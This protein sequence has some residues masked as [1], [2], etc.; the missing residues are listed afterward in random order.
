MSDSKK[1]AESIYQSINS[2]FS[3]FDTV[4]EN[5]N[6]LVEYIE[7][8]YQAKNEL[9]SDIDT[10]Y[11][12]KE[13][14]KEKYQNALIELYKKEQELQAYSCDGY[15]SLEPL[16]VGLFGEWGSGKTRLLKEI[17]NQVIQK[18]ERT[19]KIWEEKQQ[20]ELNPSPLQIPIFFNAWRF[21]KDEHIIIPLF[22]TMLSELEKYDYI[23]SIKVIKQKLQILL[24]SIVKNLQM[25]KDFDIS[26]IFSKDFKL[27]A[28]G[29]FFNIGSIFKS[30][31]EQEQEQ[32]KEHSYLLEQ[33]LQSG[34]LES[35]YVQI[36]KWIEKITILDNVRFI[37]LID[38]LDRCLPEN[39]LKMLESIKLFLDVPGCAFVL[40]VD[41][42]VVERG[43]EHHYR[44]YLQ[45][46]KYITIR[47][48]EVIQESV[49]PNKTN[50]PITGAEYLEKMVQLPF[51]IPQQDIDDVKKIII[52]RYSKRF[53]FAKITQKESQ[54]EESILSQ[55]QTKQNTVNVKDK[56]LLEFFATYIPRK[57]RKI[58]RTIELYQSKESLLQTQNIE[59]DHI[60]LAKLTLLELFA[61]KLYRVMQNKGFVDKFK[62]LVE[63]KEKFKSLSNTNKIAEELKTNRNNYPQKDYENI[64][65]LLDILR[66]IYAHRVEFNLDIVF[67]TTYDKEQIL[68]QTKFKQ[69]QK[70]INIKESNLKPVSPINEKEFFDRLLSK[71]E[72][73]W[74]NAFSDDAF[75][76]NG[77]VLDSK[78]FE[79]LLKELE[80]RKELVQNPKWLELIANYLSAN[81]FIKLLETYNPFKGE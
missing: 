61:P 63:W 6:E 24:I 5:C 73:S 32:E 36:P 23:D 31:T 17:K 39:T 77:G 79:N 7:K 48:G 42:D 2:N 34:R 20:A 30:F 57:P 3:L 27:S 26:K 55:K 45:N 10:V 49:S 12:N 54:E 52:S 69:H 37:F 8:Y 62:R 53:D 40:A 60:L 46:G 25:P 72:L 50:I 76:Q 43:V 80:N 16:T 67:E 28:L 1:Y 74:S 15:N 14:F 56:E 51:R 19:K 29:G 65:T 13:V 70:P 59:I 71:D 22:Q 33:I 58:I 47:E 64:L 44:D 81:N 35:V 41:D 75:S 11:K 66:E 38:D 68:N 78:T 18:Q 21:E 9:N 4:V